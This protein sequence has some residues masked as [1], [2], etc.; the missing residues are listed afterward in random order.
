MSKR[1]EIG[2]RKSG[3]TFIEQQA[4]R[5]IERN[6]A[7]SS[8]RLAAVFGYAP[9]TVQRHMQLLVESGDVV[10]WKEPSPKGGPKVTVYGL[11]AS[12]RAPRGWAA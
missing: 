1:G 12:L 2:N 10:T 6:G 11:P 5:W 7:A 4:M 9:D 3:P 8:A